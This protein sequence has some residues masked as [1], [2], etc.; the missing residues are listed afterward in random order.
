MPASV[1]RIA[2]A[3]RVVHLGTSVAEPSF[4]ISAI[5]A[6][7]TREGRVN[8]RPQPNANFKRCSEVQ[9]VHGCRTRRNNTGLHGRKLP[10]SAKSSECPLQQRGRSESRCRT[11]GSGQREPRRSGDAGNRFIR[12]NE[13]VPPPLGEGAAL[14]T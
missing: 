7:A 14:E 8:R 10:N 9:C 6:L 5:A 3:T 12:L 11:A 1:A 2:L 13:T 4:L